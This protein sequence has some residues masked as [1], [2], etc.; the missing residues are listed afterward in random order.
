MICERIANAFCD[1]S[2]EDAV[3]DKYVAGEDLT[4][5]DRLVLIVAFSGKRIV[6]FLDEEAQEKAMEVHDAFGEIIIGLAM[7]RGAEK[8]SETD[9]MGVKKSATMFRVRKSN[10]TV[11]RQ[12]VALKNESSVMSKQMS[13]SQLTRPGTGE[14]TASIRVKT[15]PKLDPILTVPGNLDLQKSGSQ[16]AI[17]FT[18]KQDLKKKTGKDAHF[19]ITSLAKKFSGATHTKLAQPFLQ[20]IQENKISG[21]DSRLSTSISDIRTGLSGED[22]ESVIHQGATLKLPEAL[23]LLSLQNSV[24]SLDESRVTQSL[25]RYTNLDMLIKQSNDLDTLKG[26]VKLANE[27]HLKDGKTDVIDVIV[28]IIVFKTIVRVAIATK[29]LDLS[30]IVQR[31]DQG[32]KICMWL[33]KSISS[34]GK[35]LSAF[36]LDNSKPDSLYKELQPELDTSVAKMKHFLAFLKFAMSLS[37]LPSRAIW[38]LDYFLIENREA[39]Q[40]LTNTN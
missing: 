3:I 19:I 8:V 12:H 15:I 36:I 7:F 29:F 5:Q 22:V 10:I 35:C 20:A 30:A 18:A 37:S 24:L 38:N 28:S 4:A 11:A 17:P 6:G 2:S 9:E 25:K 1:E 26:P 16:F 21:L 39:F 32:K 23:N 34:W 40:I 31:I 13:V 27:I 14:S 33:A